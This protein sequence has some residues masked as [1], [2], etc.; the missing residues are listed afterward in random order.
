MSKDNKDVAKVEAEEQELVAL[1]LDEAAIE[2]N[3]ITGAAKAEGAK[4]AEIAITKAEATAEDARN[5]VVV[6]ENKASNNAAVIVKNAEK[7]AAEIIEE[8]RAKALEITNMA[9]ESG[10]QIISDSEIQSKAIKGAK[11][12]AINNI[13]EDKNFIKIGEPYTGKNIKKLLESKS[14]RVNK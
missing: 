1:T 14:I 4:I 7:L 10:K 6:I 3:K 5:R 11:Y 8:A 2:A 12:I 13:R 9:S